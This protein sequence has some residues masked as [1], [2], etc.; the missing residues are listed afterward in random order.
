MTAQH[1]HGPRRAALAALG[2]AALLVTLGETVDRAL[3]ARVQAVVRAVERARIP[4]V[5]DVAP[6][7]ATLAV[8]FDPARTS[9]GGVESAVRALLDAEPDAPGSAGQLIEIPVTYDGA[10]LESVAEATG[11]APSEVVS[12]HAGREYFAYVLGFTPGFAYLGELD[13]ALV[14]PRR[15]TPRP[16]VPAGSVAIAGAQTAVYPSATPG[17]WHIIGRTSLVLFDA[18]REQPALIQ[19]GDRVRFVPITPAGV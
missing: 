7:Y 14:L 13:P 2:E 6:S 17:G 10:D 1:S 4:G 8:Y 18:E 19:P 5:T 15:A 11:L 16:R 9:L 12:R 3:A